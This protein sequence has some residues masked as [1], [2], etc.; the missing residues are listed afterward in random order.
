[1]TEVHRVQASPNPPT[2]EEG[3]EMK[4]GMNVLGKY[5]LL[6]HFRGK[7]VTVGFTWGK[8]HVL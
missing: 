8:G 7:V 4:G 5:I 2:Q 6:L 3:M 1:M